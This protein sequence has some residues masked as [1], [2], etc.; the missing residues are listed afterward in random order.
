MKS[1]RKTSIVALLLPLAT[2]ALFASTFDAAND[3]SPTLNPNG[4]WSYGWVDSPG[5]TFHA[6]SVTST[7]NGISFWQRNATTEPFIGHNGSGFF[8]TYGDGQYNPGDLAVHPGSLGENAT[9]LF[10]APFTSTYNLSA[11]FTGV[12]LGGTTTSVSIMENGVQVFADDVIGFGTIKSFANSVSLVAGQ[13]IEFSVGFGFNEN[14]SSDT[15]KLSAT[16]T[17]A[18]VPDAASTLPLLSAGLAMIG[19]LRR[20]QVRAS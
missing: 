14:Y 10:T 16:I 15:T 13:T 4:P 3:F 12:A 2:P 9:V 19:V 7:V 6:D 20:R 5:D 8:Q 11:T 18:A 1:S 17:T